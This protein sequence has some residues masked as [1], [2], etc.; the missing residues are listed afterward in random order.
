VYGSGQLGQ[1][2]LSAIY[3]RLHF[4]QSFSCTIQAYGE[5]GKEKRE[6]ESTKNE[7]VSHLRRLRIFHFLTF[8]LSNFF[9]S[10]VFPYNWLFINYTPF[11]YG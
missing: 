5:K 1:N 11:I 4:G 7:N 6:S 10:A 9:T 8:S 3:G 2:S